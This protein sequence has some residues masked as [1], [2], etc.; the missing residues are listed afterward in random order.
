MRDIAAL[1]ASDASAILSLDFRGRD[2]LG[3]PEL[4][5]QPSLWPNR[6]IVMTLA[7]I[8]S[9][10]GPDLERLAM[11]RQRAG[12]RR[13]YAAGGVRGAA[14]LE[15]LRRAGAAGVLVASALHDG[16][17]SPTDLAEFS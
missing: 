15:A 7:R 8:G 2:F 1:S 10:D 4:L 9:S 13:V 17:L 14:D 6:L 11:I 5:E 12:A 3:P 16:R